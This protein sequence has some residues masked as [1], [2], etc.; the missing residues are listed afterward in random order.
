MHRRRGSRARSRRAPPARR[1]AGRRAPP[2]RRS[3]ARR[4]ARG[5]SRSTQSA[6]GARRTPPRAAASSSRGG[7]RGRS[8]RGTSRP[9]TRAGRARRRARARRAPSGQATAIQPS[10]ARSSGTARSRGARSSPA[11]RHEPAARRPGAEYMSSCEGGLVERDVAV[12]ADAVAARAPE[13]REQRDRGDV[14]AREIDE[15]EP[16]AG[17]RPVG[18]AGEAHP[19]RERLHQVVVGRLGR[20]RPGHPEARERAADDPRVDVLQVRVAE[21]ELGGPSPRR[22]EK[23]ASDARTRS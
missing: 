22:F 12:A 16:A 15:R 9:P 21:A 13:A 19:A 20:A 2:G 3:P 6:S 18:L 23:T 10:A 4:D 8:C 14:A 5:A 17:R 11:R 1:P 7:G